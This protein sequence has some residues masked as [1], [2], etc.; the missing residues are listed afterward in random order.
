MAFY[1]NV[2]LGGGL[3]AGYAAQAFIEE[4]LQP[5]QLCI[6]SA[7]SKLPY[8]RPPLSKAFLAGDETGDEILINDPEFYEQNGI[9]VMLETVVGRVDLDRKTL[10][11]SEDEPIRYEKLLIA[12]GTRARRLDI[13]GAD[14]ETVY[15]LREVQDA[16]Q[17]RSA[18]RDAEKA[19]VLGGSF[20]G[21]EVTSVLRQYALETHMVFPESRVWELFFTPEMSQFFQDYY[22][23]RGVQIWPGE[24]PTAF[25]GNGQLN[26]VEL[27]SGRSLPA[28]M[29]VAGVGVLPNTELF[30]NSDLVIDDGIVVNRFLETDVPDVYAAGDVARYED[31]LFNKQRRIEHWDNARAQ[32]LHAAR[33]MMGQREVFRYVPYFFSD[34]F[35]LSYE[36]WGDTSEANHIVYRGNP[37]TTSF[38]VWWLKDDRLHGAFV[39]DR[40]DEERERAQEWIAEGTPIVNADAL[41]DE[42]RPLASA[43]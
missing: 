33:A 21:M 42:D 4:G 35:D 7:E 18:Q 10:Y 8:E 26:R 20:I 12:T 6:I 1:E 9:K 13:S 19:V 36:F 34:V 2:I 39:M 38:S 43:V 32:G 41:A 31:V 3:V 5:N 11:T 16:R 22:E 25:E 37:E 17:I 15:Y 29:V 40:P 14:R 28:D 24:K 27:E 23:E 30:E